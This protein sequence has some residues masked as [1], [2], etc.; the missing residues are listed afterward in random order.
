MAKLDK[1]RYTAGIHALD[2]FNYG[3]Q[4]NRKAVIQKNPKWK[5]LPL[6]SICKNMAD[7]HWDSFRLLLLPKILQDT[8]KIFSRHPY[9]MVWVNRLE[10][11]TQPQ[12]IYIASFE[13][14][15]SLHISGLVVEPI[16]LYK[17][18]FNSLIDIYHGDTA[19]IM[20][21]III[22]KNQAP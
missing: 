7:L 8:E 15:E 16:L 22:D 14:N 2:T 21:T 3:K 20:H 17:A 4:I 6:K 11:L 18:D 10:H 9:K 5:K 13:E 19:H 12:K 1:K